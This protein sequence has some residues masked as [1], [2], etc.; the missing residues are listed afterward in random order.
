M[1][2][3]SLHRTLRGSAN[4][5]LLSTC[6]YRS[7]ERWRRLP[8]RSHCAG[9]GPLCM[10]LQV[11]PDHAVL[12]RVWRAAGFLS[13][14][15]ASGSR[16]WSG[17]ELYKNTSGIGAASS[18][19]GQS[20]GRQPSMSRGSAFGAVQPQTFQT[21][22]QRRKPQR[23]QGRRRPLRQ[24]ARR[25]GIAKRNR[26][27]AGG[28]AAGLSRWSARRTWPSARM[29][30]ENTRLGL[31]GPLPSAGNSLQVRFPDFGAEG[32]SET[33]TCLCLGL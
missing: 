3:C 29:C 31:G 27:R 6:P 26:L 10:S 11:G 9:R 28:C 22:G 8:E 24:A 20:V 30:Q 18:Q 17:D 15:Q 21:R 23:R 12:S 16:S 13:S 5:Y 32:H 33:D 19:N 7:Q 25:A 4:Q 1:T 2:F 14:A